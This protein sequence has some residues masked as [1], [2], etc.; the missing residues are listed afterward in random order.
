MT[1]LKEKSEKRAA[2]VP[3]WLLQELVPG[4]IQWEPVQSKQVR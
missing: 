1:D 2:P 4:S 3:E